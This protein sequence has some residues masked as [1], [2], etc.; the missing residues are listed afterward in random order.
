MRLFAG[1]ILPFI[2]FAIS[3]P[4][5]PDWQS[6]TAWRLR[7]ASS[8]APG[9]AAALSVFAVQH[10]QH[11]P[12]VREPGEFPRKCLGAIRGFQ[13]GAGGGR[14]LAHF[15]FRMADSSMIWNAVLSAMA[16]L[17]LW[18]L[19]R[20]LGVFCSRIPRRAPAAQSPS[21][22]LRGPD[23]LPFVVFLWFL[24]CAPPWAFASYLAV[25]LRLIRE[26]NPRFRFTLA[27]FSALWAGSL[28]IARL[29][30]FV[31]LDARRVFAAADDRAGRLFRLHCRSQRPSQRRPRRGLSRSQRDDLSSERPIARLQAFELLLAASAPR[32]IRLPPDL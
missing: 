21:C 28:P 20:F 12:A 24:W 26:R 18:V 11:G 4:D 25:S 17:L 9:V 22:L 31:Y 27:N 14:I 23:L 3:F 32:A 19:W 6:G 2:C 30:G 7:R 16:A 10:D 8:F 13:R 15:S 1:V 29:A 5:R